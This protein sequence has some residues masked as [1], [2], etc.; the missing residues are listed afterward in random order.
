M[1]NICPKVETYA[2]V[3]TANAGIKHQKTFPTGSPGGTL[4]GFDF[5]NGITPATNATTLIAKVYK[6]EAATPTVFVEVGSVTWSA[7]QAAWT[8]V[9]TDITGPTAAVSAAGNI[10]LTTA[11]NVFKAGDVL[12]V[13]TTVKATAATTGF[14]TLY[15]E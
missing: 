3:P 9:Y 15:W 6:A 12:K 4:I 11:S 2:T 14:Y 7:T 10:A 13:V 8:G 5:M 1:I